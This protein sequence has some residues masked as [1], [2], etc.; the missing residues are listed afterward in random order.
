MRPTHHVRHR[1]VVALCL[2]GG[3]ASGSLV[4]AEAA[5]ATFCGVGATPQPS[6]P[7]ERVRLASEEVRLTKVVPGGADGE[8][9]ATD[10]GK[11]AEADVETAGEADTAKRVSADAY[12]RVRTTYQLENVTDGAA[13]QTIAFRD[14]HVD[15]D[16]PDCRCAT[17]ME[18][19]EI[20]GERTA[21]TGAEPARLDLVIPPGETRRIERTYIHAEPEQDATVGA[22][23][24]SYDAEPG[25]A[26]RGEVGRTRL[27]FEL[28]WRPWNIRYPATGGDDRE[29]GDETL[30]KGA[31]EYVR[32]V[33][34][35]EDGEATHTVVFGAR[36]WEPDRDIAVYL[37]APDPY[38]LT[39]SDRRWLGVINKC[40]YYGGAKAYRKAQEAETNAKIEEL[41]GHV[42][43]SYPAQLLRKCRH[44]VEAHHG[45]DFDDEEL[46]AF[47]Y[48][49]GEPTT[50]AL[51]LAEVGFQK[52]PD[53][54]EELLEDWE[55]TYATFVGDAAAYQQK[56]DIEVGGTG[57]AA[58]ERADGASQSGRRGSNASPAEPPSRSRDEPS[59]SVGDLFRMFV[60]DMV[61]LWPL[62][63]P[64]GVLALPML[65]FV[66]KNWLGRREMD[67]ASEATCLL[68]ESNDVEARGDDEFECLDCGFDSSWR[69]RPTLR[70]LFQQLRELRDAERSFQRAA[71]EMES[72]KRWSLFDILGGSGQAKHGAM[73]E[74]GRAQ[75]EGLTKLKDLADEYPELLEMPVAGE[76]LDV[77][78]LADLGID[79]IG[80]DIKAHK[81]I[82][83][84]YEQV[85]QFL[86]VVSSVREQ[87]I[88]EIRDR[89]NVHEYDVEW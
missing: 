7:S 61:S 83:E 3:L 23:A 6:E 29:H 42:A 32:Q 26:W 57:A 72:A 48:G 88:S 85:N 59:V 35:W 49:S 50:N 28:P 51:G 37:V 25:A 21:L 8:S 78:S 9:D 79:F 36:D 56:H 55:R 12:W 68:C 86:E 71:D 30:P 34:T 65:F 39:G 70:P 4:P 20:D 41:L 24:V 10:A 1:L 84:S 77:S 54:R 33:G 52:N 89:A 80:T 14:R 69:E 67:R 31:V 58:S 16:C 81:Q 27:V 74:A 38:A 19:V 63:I 76:N 45:R 5:A 46:D 11:K 82:T 44:A 40:P 13:E 87:L 53:Y 15:T 17:A 60:R 73:S 47:F 2:V 18:A 43:E 62:L 66:V 64:L 75:A 22:E